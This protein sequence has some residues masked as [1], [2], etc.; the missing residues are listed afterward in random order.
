MGLVFAYLDPNTGS[1]VIQALIGIIAGI[2]L[3]GR[4]SISLFKDRIKSKFSKPSEP[5]KPVDPKK[6]SDTKKSGDTKK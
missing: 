6:S 3:F 1:L 5:E 4:K 2:A